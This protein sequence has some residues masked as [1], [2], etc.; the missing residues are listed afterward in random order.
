MLIFNK[1]TFR[2]FLIFFL[3]FFSFSSSVFSQNSREKLSL[4]PN[5]LSRKI[6]AEAKQN[7][8][9]FEYLS[10]QNR[11]SDAWYSQAEK[12]IAQATADPC[13]KALE[14]EVSQHLNIATNSINNMGNAGNTE[15][16]NWLQKMMPKFENYGYAFDKCPKNAPGLSGSGAVMSGNTSSSESLDQEMQLNQ[17]KKS[18]ANAAQKADGRFLNQVQELL[19]SMSKVELKNTKELQASDS[20]VNQLVME[21]ENDLDYSRFIQNSVNKD[22]VPADSEDSGKDSTTCDLGPTLNFYYYSVE[23]IITNNTDSRIQVQPGMDFGCFTIGDADMEVNIP[24][25]L[26][27]SNYYEGNPVDRDKDDKFYLNS[28]IEP[29]GAFWN[30]NFWCNHPIPENIDWNFTYDFYTENSSL[31]LKADKEKISAKLQIGPDGKPINNITQGL[32]PK[33][34]VLFN[35]GKVALSY[36]LK[37]VRTCNDCYVRMVLDYPCGFHSERCKRCCHRHTH[38]CKGVK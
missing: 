15:Y 7:K 27:C 29:K 3:T 9:A 13:N 24:T 36:D 5:D 17:I 18:L 8:I 19:N 1:V 25:E 11:L 31:D 34:K 6:Q 33:G 4:D 28:I 14:A 20:I 22:D 26:C 32:Q 16:Q 30:W 21:N 35:D 10:N 37:L 38:G 2:R 12:Y 23:I